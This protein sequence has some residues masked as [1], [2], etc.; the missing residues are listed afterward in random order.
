MKTMS[1]RE[2]KN[3]FGLMIDTA[4]AAPVLIEKHGRGV[5]RLQPGTPVKV[6]METPA[7]EPWKTTVHRIQPRHDGNQN[8]IVTETIGLIDHINH[9]KGVLHF[10]VAKGVD[11]TLPLAQFAGR[12]EVGEAVAVRMVRYHDRKGPRTRTLS[13][14]SSAQTVSPSVMKSFTDDVEVRNGLGFTS[15][16]IFIP[17]DIVAGAAIAD[18]AMV[19]GVAVINFDKKRSTWGWKAIKARSSESGT[20]VSGQ[21]D[22]DFD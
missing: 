14:I 1:A 17:P 16:G 18:G 10:V 15:T 13:A 11:G 19:D 21:S 7:N 12:A 9:A 3:G 22:D 6:Q 4:R 20:P 8:D 2:A 5:V